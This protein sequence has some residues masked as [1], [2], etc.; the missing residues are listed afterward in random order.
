MGTP[1]ILTDKD[2][3]AIITAAMERGYGSLKKADKKKG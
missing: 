3:E 2:F 1:H